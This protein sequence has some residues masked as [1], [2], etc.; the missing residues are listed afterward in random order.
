VIA[1]YAAA[2]L[3]AIPLVLAFFSPLL[4][5]CL[6]LSTGALPLALGPEGWLA[7]DFGR[8][9]LYSVRVFGLWLASML[10]IVPSLSRLLDYGLRFRWH[11]AFLF[12]AVT[13]MIWSPSLIY[14]ARM[15]AKLTAPFLFLL[16]VMVSVSSWTALRSIERAMWCSGILVAVI[17]LGAVVAGYSTFNTL[18]GLGVPGL[19]PAGTS[20]HLAILAMLA[21]AAARTR[22]PRAAYA[23]IALV[24]GAMVIAGFTRI[25]IAGLFL[26]AAVVLWMSSASWIRWLFPLAGVASV[27]ALFLLSETFRRRMFKNQDSMS[28][29]MFTRD[30]SAV[31]DQI[32]GSGRF[33][34]WAYVIR[35]FFDPHP[36]FG[37]GIGTTQH[38]FYTHQLGLSVIHSEYVRLLAE[39]GLIGIVLVVLAFLAY[40]IRLRRIYSLAKS[41]QTKTYALAGLGSL[42]V[43]LVFMATDNAIDYVTSSGIF[44][45]SLIAMSEKSRDLEMAQEGI[46]QVQPVSVVAETVSSEEP[47]PQ[48][49]YPLLAG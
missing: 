36:L 40:M 11:V 28:L 34:H 39:V 46:E 44:V 12:F 38:Y 19:G 47:V 6:A 4:L 31:L 17:S 15:V 23:L 45:F 32:H 10:L 9:D 41:N 20:S 18:V 49:R 7:S 2:A 29:D 37:S 42:I 25:T 30:P 26:G 48:R 22:S 13:A 27:P 1:G 5:I 3:V 43:Y 16:M 14:S 33:D 8:L 24:F 35:T 21:L